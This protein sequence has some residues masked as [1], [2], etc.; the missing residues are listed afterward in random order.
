MRGGGD[1]AKRMFFVAC[2][3]RL[4][5]VG[6]GGQA[7]AHGSDGWP[8]DFE[9]EFSVGGLEAIK[10]MPVLKTGRAIVPAHLLYVVGARPASRLKRF[11]DNFPHTHVEPTMDCA[12]AL[13]QFTDDKM[14]VARLFKGF[15]DLGA[16]LD[17][18]MATSHLKIV[19]LHK[20][21]GGQ[22]DIGKFGGIGHELLVHTQE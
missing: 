1:E 2:V 19:M 22:Y 8:I 13:R 7:S 18:A 3:D 9:M 5:M 12:Q 11:V 21:R 6:K 16:D 15:D 14:I 10:E 17:I 20:C 4:G